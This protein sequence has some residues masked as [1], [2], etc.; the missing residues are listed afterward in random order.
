MSDNRRDY[1]HE[2]TWR[3]PP[4][5]AD[6]SRRS[7]RPNPS[8]NPRDPDP[9]DPP[10]RSKRMSQ[11]LSPD[12]TR[13]SPPD[14]LRDP[15]AS[16]RDRGRSSRDERNERDEDAPVRHRSG[17]NSRRD[18]PP[19]QGK[20]V[21]PPRPR[22]PAPEPP[23]SRSPQASRTRGNYDDRDDRG[24]AGGSWEEEEER[25]ELRRRRPQPDRVDNRVDRGMPPSRGGGVP[26]RR[27]AH[28]DDYP[29]EGPP[30]PRSRSSDQWREQEP[31][32]DRERGRERESVQ[33]RGRR[34]PT[35]ESWDDD[36]AGHFEQQDSVWA[37]AWQQNQPGGG[38]RTDQPGSSG[39]GKRPAGQKPAPG[40]RGGR[41]AALGERSAQLGRRASSLGETGYVWA[42]T[43]R[44]RILST[45]RGRI[46]T[47]VIAA[48]LLL[49]TLGSVGL[50]YAEYHHVKSQATVALADLK[51]AETNLKLLETNP[52]DLTAIAQ[53]QAD[54]QQSNVAFVQLNDSIQHIPGVLGITPIVGSDV[55]A[56]LQIGP[57]AVEATQAGVLGCQILGILAPKLQKPLATNIPGLNSA[58]IAAVD[59]DFNTLYGLAST[60]L[61]Q[62][63]QLP[64]SAA[65]LDP[66]LGSLLSAVSTNLPEFQQG[67]QDAKSFMAVLPQLL[68]V[69]QPAN[70]LLE[71]MDSTELR[72]GGG[73]IGNVGTLTLSGGR[74]QGKPQ[75]KDVDIID[76][77]DNPYRGIPIP[78]QF[79]W[80]T[81]GGSSLL[82]QDSNMD[83]D[84]PSDAQ[85]AIHL[86]SVA[87]GK[88]FYDTPT[89]QPITANSFQGVIAIT[90]W[91]IENMLQITGP[92]S[93]PT[94]NGT[95]VKVN[96]SNLISEIHFFQLT[97][98]Q[99][100]PS[101]LIDPNPICNGQSYRKCFTGALFATMLAELGK[102]ST[103]NFGALGKLIINSLHTKDIQI[104]LTQSGAEA[105][106]LHHDLASAVSAPKSGD[107]M[108]VVD[109]N[110]NGIKANNSLDYNWTDNITL[111]SSGDA[112]HHL[113]LTY[114][115]P[116][117]F[118]PSRTR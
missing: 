25:Q 92:I 82:L 1:D 103:T 47:A 42:V 49:A 70:Y 105:L 76:N 75:I 63:E 7:H 109:A 44:K 28:E 41:V 35:W 98:G 9:R 110:I 38:Q 33:G 83:A 34:E 78:P 16:H 88:N 91:L 80:F 8:D 39:R 97:P 46:I 24:R 30:P 86:Y 112:T 37:P 107:G 90:P 6:R 4:D 65:S 43:Q 67:L 69:G 93:V 48:S 116:N 23:E 32:W 99:G 74:L 62:V 89:G 51:A 15:G 87:G 12:R 27:L 60:I 64:S 117:N 17:T 3:L 19:N 101:D 94:S 85:R 45:R 84:F 18:Q 100:G 96:S 106:L 102:V 55:D 111:D 2:E 40:T 10:S 71:V 108:M 52:F 58:D 66:R 81:S 118:P 79:S 26:S 50:A 72:P 53:A 20:F 14:E 61:Q 57:I 113:T 54:L 59:A 77:N 36:E 21:S 5:R 73:F 104:Y 114:N 22:T 13:N 95:T 115:F 56:V 31:G 29:Y 68:G 11:R